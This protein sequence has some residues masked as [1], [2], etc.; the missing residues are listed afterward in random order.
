MRLFLLIFFVVICN[1]V[2]QILLKVAALDAGS[3]AF[4]CTL[5]FAFICLGFS[6]LCWFAALRLKPLSFLHPFGALVYIL[7]PGLAAFIFDE[8]V[9]V[10]YILG[11]ACIVAGI[12]ITSG[13]VLPPKPDDE[14]QIC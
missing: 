4:W 10:P 5:T 7:V 8:P 6:F 14:N 2:A 11:I 1:S 3:L 12:C 9:S 13:A